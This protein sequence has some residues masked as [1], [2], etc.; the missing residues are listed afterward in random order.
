[1]DLSFDIFDVE[2]FQKNVTEALSKVSYEEKLY[3][4][5]V[6]KKMGQN[7][8]R[9]N[10]NHF[11]FVAEDQMEINYTDLLQEEKTESYI[12]LLK[13]FSAVSES[14][15]RTLILEKQFPEY[16]KS[17]KPSN[18]GGKAGLIFNIFLN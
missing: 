11:W 13:N 4:R 10:T 16:K 7:S 9:N 5:N 2:S 6:K 15:S 18:L 8:D 1:M 12:Q 3:L 14:I 17:I